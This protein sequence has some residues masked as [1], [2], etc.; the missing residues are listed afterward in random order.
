MYMYSFESYICVF[1]C[2]CISQPTLEWGYTRPGHFM[3]NDPGRYCNANGRKYGD[4]IDS[5]VGEIPEG[6][7]VTVQWH[8]V[9]TED[10]A[11]GWQYAT[12][13]MSLTWSE[14]PVPR[15]E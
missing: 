6:W 12:D 11:D 5:V 2:S 15:S 4:T 10:D 14:K 3:P 9:A 1:V 8:S 7:T 13:F